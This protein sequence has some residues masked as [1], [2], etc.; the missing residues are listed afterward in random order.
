MKKNGSVTV[1][2]ALSLMI[3]ASFLFALLEAGRVYGLSTC[4]ELVSELGLESVCAEYQTCLWDNYKL[5][6]LDGA[7]GGETFAIEKV[8][9]ALEKRIKKNL[10]G[11]EGAYCFSMQLDTATP[12][13]YQLLTDGEGSI[14]LKRTASYMKD[15]LP[16]ELIETIYEQYKEGSGTM[17]QNGQEED[18]V[19]NAQQAI[20]QAREEQETA[21]K[22]SM[23]TSERRESTETESVE[24]ESEGTESMENPLELVLEL[25]RNAVLGMVVENTGDI[26]TRKVDVSNGLLQRDCVQGTIQEE[27]D[28]NWYEKILILEY[29][30]KYFTDYTDAGKGRHALA[31]EM[32]YILCGKEEDKA[33]L[34]GAV[35]RLLFVRE[36]GNVAHILGS[37]EK[38][39]ETLAIA[40]VLAGFTG[41]PAIIKVVQ[42]GV[43]AA[44]AYLESIQDVRTL[45]QGGKIAL[46]KNG[47]QWNIQMGNLLESFQN[48]TK[49]KD[50]ANGL[51]YQAYVKQFLFFM[52]NKELAYRMLDVMEQN[53]RMIPS[54]KNIRMDSMICRLSYQMQ[55]RASALFSKIS[56]IGHSPDTYG[57][58]KT[59]SFSYY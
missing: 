47:E 14:F 7:Y 59:K 35:N 53:I 34:E 46:V 5:L 9:D 43:V 48:T 1:F 18:S 31:Y 29:L 44:W 6:C 51:T 40:N 41:N 11:R 2:A 55:Y 33:N 13:S 32:E 39:N 19:E 57:M 8:T 54:G 10:E 58:K 38:R 21:Q 16:A 23:G 25:K 37:Q 3:I 15:N 52:K 4:A 30:D 49:A 12:A 45:L 20:E 36:A 17:E 56:A 22:E 26:S 28:V 42:I 24:M 27:Q 50:C